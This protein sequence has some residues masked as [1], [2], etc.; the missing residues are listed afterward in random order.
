M[1]EHLTKVQVDE[2]QWGANGLAKTQKVMLSLST[3]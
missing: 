1:V 2:R 3:D